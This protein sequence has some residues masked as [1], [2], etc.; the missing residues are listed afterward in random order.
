MAPDQW[1][2][3]QDK[4]LDIFLRFMTKLETSNGNKINVNVDTALFEKSNSYNYSMIA[5]GHKRT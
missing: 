2:D 4:S 5:R 3:A 1:H